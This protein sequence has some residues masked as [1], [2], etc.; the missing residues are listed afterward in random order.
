M[1]Y[2][3]G[4]L[5]QM[6]ALCITQENINQYAKASG[7]MNPLHIDPDFAKTTRFGGT[8]AHGLMSV[9]F[10]SA[11]LTDHF[12]REWASTGEIEL[13]FLAPVRA[14][15]TIET[16]AEVSPSERPGQIVLKVY[17]RNQNGKDVISGTAKIESGGLCE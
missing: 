7:D 3:V 15:D 17:C 2:A 5:L 8:I 9:G 4:E 6:P 14:G 10:I 16:A 11:L 1:K 13:S 12:G